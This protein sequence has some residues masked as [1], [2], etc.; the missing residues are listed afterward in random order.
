MCDWRWAR[1]RRDPT[2]V[3]VYLS[4]ISTFNEANNPFPQTAHPPDHPQLS[5]FSVDLSRPPRISA[6]TG[7][8]S[9]AAAWCRYDC[10]AGEDGLIDRTHAVATRRS[11]KTR[12]STP[13]CSRRYLLSVPA[14][15]RTPF[16][17]TYCRGHPLSWCSHPITMPHYRLQ[18]VRLS[19]CLSVSLPVCRT[20]ASNSRKKSR[21]LKRTSSVL[22]GTRRTVFLTSKVKGQDHEMYHNIRNEMHTQNS[23]FVPGISS[24]NLDHIILLIISY[25]GPCNSVNYLGHSKNV[26][27]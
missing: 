14:E 26:S 22:R 13:R 18:T 15:A 9:A 21:K 2:A 27:W 10:L 8:G 24:R 3:V 12:T 6:A 23:N 5:R 17:H 20:P 16:A 1:R 4:S 25:T 11:L 19:L 7:S